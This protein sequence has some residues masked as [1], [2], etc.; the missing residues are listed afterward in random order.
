MT[1]G[2][3]CDNCRVFGPS[4]PAG[5]FYVAQQPSEEEPASSLAAALFGNPQEPLTFCTVRCLA[6]W[7]YVRNAAADTAGTEPGL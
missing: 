3:Q 4:R 2:T 1:A 7:A 5:W 6:D